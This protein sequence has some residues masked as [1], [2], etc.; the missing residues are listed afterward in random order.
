MKGWQHGRNQGHALL[1]P[2]GRNRE[3]G[4][5]NGD[6]DAKGPVSWDGAE[7]SAALAKDIAAFA[8]SRNGGSIVIGKKQKE[9][10]GFDPVGV[11]EE[12]AAT[13]DTTKVAQWVNNRFSP[14]IRLVCY[15]QEV[16][17]RLFVV[18]DVL[19]FDDMPIMCVKSFQGPNS[20]EHILR[21]QTI[22]VRNANAESVPVGVKE[23]PALIGLATRKRGDEM[24]ASLDAMLRGRPLV[25][26]ATD[27]KQFGDEL[28]KVG[29]VLE[30][31]KPKAAHG[32]W[33]FA[34]HPAKYDA[35]RWT[36]RECLV[37]L[38]Q[39]HRFRIVQEFPPSHT[40]TQPREWGIANSI[41]GE[42]WALTRSGLFVDR[43][44]FRE[45]RMAEPIRHTCTPPLTTPQN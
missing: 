20:K 37:G 15:P 28:A 24:L 12:Q 5:K 18:I 35:A 13:F 41:Y 10:G 40:G 19:E 38:I 42:P 44:P 22:Y 30:A 11:T 31:L 23:L 3:N 21:E 1:G 8:N 39:K 14:P 29:A 6:I 26:P 16:D 33:F 45:N 43:L 34:F 9:L 25:P 2:V 36:D 32:E 7:Q 27:D 4:G 17:G